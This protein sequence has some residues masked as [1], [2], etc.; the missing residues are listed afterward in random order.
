VILS[1]FHFHSCEDGGPRRCP[2][3]LKAAKA[4]CPN[5]RCKR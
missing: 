5:G 1:G 4:A 2:D 3:C